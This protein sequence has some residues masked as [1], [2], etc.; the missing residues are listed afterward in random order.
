MI[1]EITNYDENRIDMTFV[2]RTW[3]TLRAGQDA[4]LREKIRA[5]INEEFYNEKFISNVFTRAF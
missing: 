4:E 5:D 2:K 3:H 1:R